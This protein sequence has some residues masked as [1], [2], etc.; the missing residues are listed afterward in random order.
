MLKIRL[1]KIISLCMIVSLLLAACG[2]Q[3]TATPPAVEPT[4]TPA[5]PTPAATETKPTTGPVFVP[6]VSDAAPAVIQTSPALGAELALDGAIELVFNQPMDRSSVEK[7]FQVEPTVA[8]SFNWADDRTVS[9][10]PAAALP[11]SGQYRVSLNQSAESASGAALNDA[12]QFRFSTVGF[13]QVAQTLPAADSSDVEAGSTITVIFNRPVVPLTT[14]NEQAS[15]PQPLVLT[16]AVAGK[17]EWLNTSIYV[18]TPDEPLAGGATYTARIEAGLEDTTGGLL[19]KAYTW[20]FTVQPPLVVWNDPSEG[21]NLTPIDQKITVTFNQP[22]DAGSIGSLLTVTDANGGRVPGVIGVNAEVVTF[23]PETE[24]AFDTTYRVNIGAGVLSKGAALSGSGVGMAEP[25]S[26]SFT[27]VPLPRIVSTYPADGE[28][29]ADPYTGFTITFNTPI[30]PSTVLPNIRMTPPFT[31]TGVYTYYSPWDQT[32]Y[33]D[34]S[35]K[36]SS[37]YKV[38]IGPDI[39]DPYG[40]LT[41]QSMTVAFRTRQLDPNAQL[42]VPDLVG[43]YN[44]Y[45]PARLFVSYQNVNRLDFGLYRLSSEQFYHL[46][47]YWDWDS[48]KPDSSELIRAWKQPVESVL[49]QPQYSPIDLVEGGGTLEPGIYYLTLDSPDLDKD[50]YY[51]YGARHILVVSTLNLTIKRAEDQLLVWATDLAE[52]TP[53]SGLDLTVR[54]EQGSELTSLTTGADGVAM[55]DPG[56]DNSL[57]LESEQ[58]FALGSENWGQGLSSW[59]F[60]LGD[61]DWAQDYR[62]HIYTDR[63]IY[64]PDQTVHFRGVVRSEDDASY[65]PVKADSIKI[66]IYNPNWETVLEKTLSLGEY[67]T[68]NGELELPA[69]AALGDYTIE[70]NLYGNTFDQNFQVAAYRAPQYEVVV[71]PDQDAIVAGNPVRAVVE[72]KTFFGSPVAN[73]AVEWN[74]MSDSYL[75][76]GIG[77]YSYSDNDDPWILYRKWWGGPVTSPEPILSGSGT[78]D[79]QGRLVIELP[80]GQLA[81]LVNEQGSQSITIEATV[82]GSDNSPVSGRKSVVVHQGDFYIGVAPHEYVSRAGDETSADLIVLGWDLQRL[83][84]IDLTAELYRREYENTFVENETGGGYWEWQQNDVLVQTIT[85]T[86]DEKGEA[87]AVLT[88]DQGGTYRVLVKGMDGGER[89]VRSSAFFWVTSPETISWQRDNNDHINLIS[90]KLLYEPGETAEILI[91]SPF[92]GQQL[93]LVTIE[94]ADIKQYE[95]VEMT[96]NS[97]VYRLPITAGYAPNIFVSAVIIKGQ[98]ASSPQA[99]FKVG[100]VALE[101]DTR[102]QELT[103]SLTPSQQQAGPGDTLT[104]D[105]LVTDSSGE[106]VQGEF[107][108]DLADKAVLTL[109]PR[110]PNAIVQAFYG[111]RALGVRTASGLTISVNR[112]VEQQQIEY[113]G[114]NHMVMDGAEEEMAAGMPPSPEPALATKE[115]PVRQELGIA[116]SAVAPAGVEVRQEFADTAYWNPSVVTDQSGRATIEIKLPDNLTTWTA[117]AVGLTSDT[118]VG[119]GTVDVIATKPLLV[120]PV[121]P[122]FFVVGDKVQLA[123]LVNNNTDS[124]LT[125]D[126]ALASAGVTLEEGEAAG[127]QVAIPA[128]GEAKVTWWIVA[129]D[130]EYAD[131]IFSAVSG[132]YSDASKPTLATGPDQT[133]PVYRYTA[134]EVVGT[135]G[136]IAEGG[137]RTEIISLPPLFDE[138]QGELRLEIDPSLAAGMQAGLDYLEHYE[139]ECIEQTVSRFLPNVLTY[140]ALQQLGIDDKDLEQ[141]LDQQIATGLDRLYQGQN[142]DGGWGWWPQ[143]ESNPYVSAYVLFALSRTAEVGY[144]VKSDVMDRAADF[145]T[146]Q[147][148]SPLKLNAY[149]EAN[150][151]AWLLFVLQDYGRDE[152]SNLSALYEHRE[153]LSHYGRAFLAMALGKDDPR[154]QTLLSDLNNAAILSATGAHWEE[155][156]YDWWAMNTDTRSTA[157]ILDALTRLNPDNEF[158]PNVVRWLMIARQEGIW[159]TT[160]E[161][162]WALI[163][164]TDW[165]AYTGELKADYDWSAWLNGEEWTSGTATVDNDDTS[166]V[167]TRALSDLLSEQSNELVIGRGD[168]PGRLY[169]TA[170]LRA[171]LPV[172]AVEAANRG[173]IVS[174]QYVMA[175]CEDGTSCP[176]VTEAQVGDEIRV[177]LTIIAPN[178][179]YYLVVEDPLPSGAEAIDPSLATTSVLAEEPGLYRDTKENSWW[180]YWWWNWYSHSEM[181]DEKV[182]LFADY[183]AAGTYEYTYTFRATL[184]GEFRVMPAF[185]SEFY[186]PEVFG[187]TEGSL[188]TITP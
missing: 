31:P 136:Q 179:L 7:A 37:D 133:L 149:R 4:S 56:A 158:I 39:A 27:T 28:Q 160:Q 143:K 47:Y 64:R 81:D 49:N 187:R 44:A 8:G 135:A 43:T 115:M 91:P 76:P 109:Q 132:E 180:D 138:R 75:F 102:Q 130:V 173:I 131:L 140:R 59:D 94:R 174:R 154:V 188:F 22:I 142:N 150:Q 106:P 63:P 48:F 114:E 74:V 139:Y 53:V 72:V 168:G 24:L 60:G 175:G 34:F 84:G 104:Y 45:D 78:T 9:F 11:R 167:V 86:T 17:G 71:T 146:T 52:G 97:F 166:I 67:G 30:D 145:L 117:R 10:K 184:P 6:E 98:D 153:K 101:V 144:E 58:P 116:Q 120:R 103:V 14:L 5:E 185:A 99:D 112:L 73:A 127:Q 3:P 108:L 176:P 41:G 51:W 29:N 42:I 129:E 162:A 124:D 87:S 35:A 26:W 80:A 19:D 66:T 96:S 137:S 1:W 183:V 88:P 90:D 147:L 57:W 38:E 50:S 155:D 159:E 92:E 54:D 16:P 89:A 105:L 79:G 170:H 172:E 156:G 126:V 13:L 65:T 93:A 25:Y 61:S 46:Q 33:L 186:F 107:S 141:K 40:N 157:I 70:A 123:A 111:Q 18:F 177:K 169:Y 161:T 165:M 113:S 118:L 181:R 83:A 36:P 20:S 95:V 125:V 62:V 32:Y 151:Q 55:I 12:Y 119:E 69:G 152:A 23:E 128:H 164:L 182:V 77:N 178:S 82:Y 100:Y 163:A 122:R 15:L 171:Y 134:P 121:A 85:T 68:F 110:I 2:P 21:Q 148:A